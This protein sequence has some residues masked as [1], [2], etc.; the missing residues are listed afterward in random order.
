[1]SRGTRPCDTRRA[2][3]QADARD[4]DSRGKETLTL[5]RGKQCIP[6]TTA[7]RAPTNILKYDLPH[8]CFSQLIMLLKV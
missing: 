6:A 3:G 2:V 7:Y 1:M 4:S 5:A 8:N